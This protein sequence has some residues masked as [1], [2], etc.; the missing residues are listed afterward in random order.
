MR[1]AVGRRDPLAVLGVVRGVEVAQHRLA[2]EQRA[3]AGGEV[4]VEHRARRRPRL[5]DDLDGGLA[6][7]GVVAQADRVHGLLDLDVPGRAV[8][9]VG[10]AGSRGSTRS[11]VRPPVRSVSTVA[12]SKASTETNRSPSPEPATAPTARGSSRRSAPTR[13]RRPGVSVLCTMR[14]RSPAGSTSYSTPSRAGGTT[15]HSPSGSS[16]SSRCTSDVVFEPRPSMIQRS[17]RLLET[18]IQ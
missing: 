16:L 8:T 6:R 4:D 5:D 3:L 2:L 18:P 12:W 10:C 14:S 17:S 15:R 1:R 7:L 9:R 13:G 11:A